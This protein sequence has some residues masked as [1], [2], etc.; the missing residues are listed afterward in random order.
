LKCKPWNS[1]KLFFSGITLHYYYYY[2][3]Y[4]YFTFVVDLAVHGGAGG[5]AVR[6]RRLEIN[7]GADGPV[8][9]RLGR[10]VIVAQGRL[11]VVGAAL[12]QAA[13]GV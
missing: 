8:Q 7:V 11:R 13:Q 10:P 12:H 1:T 5:L 6:L 9:E 4:Y 2:Y 3:Y